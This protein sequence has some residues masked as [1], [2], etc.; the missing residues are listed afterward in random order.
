MTKALPPQAVE[1][2]SAVL[3]EINDET[4]AAWRLGPRLSGGL[5]GGAWLITGADARAVLKWQRP[6]SDVP[7]NPDAPR[8][9]AALRAAG[10][11]TPAWLADGTTASHCTYS[12]QAFVE[13]ETHLRLDVPTAELLVDLLEQ[14]RAV[15]PPTAFSW[16]THVRDH[17]F[18]YHPSHTVL[19]AAGADVD[20]VLQ[21]ALELAAPFRDVDLPD[22]ET[23]HSDFKPANLL[24][25]AGRV[26]GVIDMDAVGRGCAAYD[27]LNAAL[28]GALWDGDPKAVERLHSFA[29]DAYGPAPV[30]VTAAT[31]TIEKA[32]WTAS[33]FPERLEAFVPKYTQWLRNLRSVTR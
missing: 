1:D 24:M 22:D 20:R 11:P 2:A 14:Q 31:L 9:V 28:E 19:T 8:V 17:V 33:S 26:A 3:S 27:A 5:L 25:D 16:T 18:S 15:E 6:D 13:G 32:G 23:V 4:G 30:L 12:I 29:A 21:Q 7:R 10:Y